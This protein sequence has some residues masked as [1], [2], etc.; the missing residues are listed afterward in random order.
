MHGLV[1]ARVSGLCYGFCTCFGLVA[2]DI[3]L[4]IAVG[5]QHTST[6]YEEPTYLAGPDYH[7][8]RAI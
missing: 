4:L 8:Q 3:K 2:F 6:H 5:V 7:G 1:A